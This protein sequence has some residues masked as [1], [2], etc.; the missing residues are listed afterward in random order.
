MLHGEGHGGGILIGLF[1]SKS[2]AIL[3]GLFNST[4]LKSYF[5]KKKTPISDLS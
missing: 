2:T 4:F 1:N 5:S 3:I